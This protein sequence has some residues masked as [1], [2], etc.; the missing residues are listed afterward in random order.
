MIFTHHNLWF[1]KQQDKQSIVVPAIA[2][3]MKETDDQETELFT[4][5]QNDIIRRMNDFRLKLLYLQQFH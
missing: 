4:T 1:S 3:I 5:L 2:L